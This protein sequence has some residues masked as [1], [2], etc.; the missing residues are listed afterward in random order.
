[1]YFIKVM[2]AHF[3]GFPGVASDKEPVCQSR[4]RGFDLWVGET[5]WRRAWQSTPV[6]LPGEPSRQRSL[7]VLLLGPQR[8]RH[9]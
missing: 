6:F 8:V 7:V 4:R 5:P 9:D 1:M 2:H 3:K